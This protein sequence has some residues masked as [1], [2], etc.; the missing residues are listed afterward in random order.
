MKEDAGK[1]ER[2]AIK[3]CSCSTPKVLLWCLTTLG[4]AAM[5]KTAELG[6]PVMY[7]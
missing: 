3:H 5:Q 4:T 7:T 2:A 6:A 1:E